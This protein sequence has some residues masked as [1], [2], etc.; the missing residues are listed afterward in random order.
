MP[1]IEL[2]IEGRNGGRTHKRQ[3][4]SPWSSI[5]LADNVPLTIA[6]KYGSIFVEITEDG[7]VLIEKRSWGFCGRSEKTGVN[8]QIYKGPIGK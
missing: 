5:E 3:S 4:N 1:A 8:Q 6:T 7:E 2:F